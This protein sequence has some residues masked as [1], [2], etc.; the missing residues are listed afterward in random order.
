MKTIRALV[1]EVAARDAAWPLLPIVVVIIDTGEIVYISK[2]AA[3]MFGYDVKELLGKP[4]D[5]LVPQDMRYTREMWR[6][7]HI[8]ADTSL[9]GIGHQTR[10][11]RKDGAEFPM[12]V[13]LASTDAMDVRISISLVVDLTGLSG[14]ISP[15]SA[16]SDVSGS[17][18]SA[19]TT[20]VTTVVAPL[21]QAGGPGEEPTK[22]DAPGR[23]ETSSTGERRDSEPA[24]SG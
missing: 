3:R 17:G 23:S 18:T 19:V 10:G 7:D 4:V 21:S 24:S 8:N 1:Y 14:R 5:V 9:M 2:S 6:K 13:G 12:H 11:L 16:S 20:T 22:D 15:P